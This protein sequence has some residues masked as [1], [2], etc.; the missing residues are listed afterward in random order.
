MTSEFTLPSLLK[1]AGP[2]HLLTSHTQ[3]YKGAKHT[4]SDPLDTQTHRMFTLQIN[5][6]ESQPKT[7]ICTGCA[8]NPSLKAMMIHLLSAL[9]HTRVNKG[10][11][12]L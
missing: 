6:Q 7:A 8:I 10:L 11:Y 5:Y 12:H 4:T 2:P 1:R 3:F 9:E